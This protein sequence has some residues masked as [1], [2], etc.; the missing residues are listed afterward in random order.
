VITAF[1]LGGSGYTV[2][3]QSAVGS[4][5]PLDL[6]HIVGTSLTLVGLF[7]IGGLATAVVAVLACLF[8]LFSF[9]WLGLPSNGLPVVAG[10]LSLVLLLMGPGCY[11]LDAR[12]F[13]WRRIEIRAPHR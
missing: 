2:L 6:P 9:A 12:F 11:S 8:L 4:T 5:S 1:A 10:G 3:Y 13:G 7:M